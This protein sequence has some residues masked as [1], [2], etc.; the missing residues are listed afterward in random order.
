MADVLSPNIRL[1][2]NAQ[3]NKLINQ[4][5][6]NLYKKYEIDMSIRE[7]ADGTIKGYKG[8][9]F[10]WF[11]FIL[12]NQ[13]NKSAIELTEDD[14]TEFIYYC[15]NKGNETRRRRR[16][17]AAMSEFFKFLRRKK[18]LKENIMEFVERPKKDNDVIVQT[19]L[20]EEQVKYMKS[21]LKEKCDLQLETYA[22]LSLST[23]AR[24]TAVSNISWKQ[25]DFQSRMINNVLEKESKIVTLFF[26]EEVK[27]LLLRLKSCR[28]IANVDDNGWVFITRYRK[29]NKA[30]KSTLQGWARIIGNM[31]DVPT[32]HP[33]DFRHS[34]A[35]ILK[36][37]GMPIDMISELLHHENIDTTRRFY[38]K[39]DKVKMIREKDKYDI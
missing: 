18:I 23:M 29:I 15:K 1:L 22:L 7:L 32:L 28:Q 33:H 5:T 26:N 37:R 34:M 13:G 11:R 25:I 14:I 27:D 17:L 24:V 4:E 19:Y 31:I 12:E 2:C 10:S 36:I 8:D 21:K 20:T 9:L 6:L 39:Q 16:R 38:L 35:Q 30:Q 3:K